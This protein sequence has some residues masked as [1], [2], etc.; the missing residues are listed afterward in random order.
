MTAPS[1]TDDIGICA[2]VAEDWSHAWRSR[3]HVLSRL[4]RYF[5]VVWVDPAPGW[6]SVLKGRSAPERETL[7]QGLI[8][9]KAETWLP[10][11]Q[12]PQWLADLTFDTR[13]RRAR[14]ILMR[15]GCKRIIL[16]LWRPEFARA[17]SSAPFDLTCY[18]I[19]DEYS[20]SST[21]VP[22]APAEIRLVTGVDQVFIHSPGLLERLGGYNPNTD[23][24]PNGVDFAAFA[25][26]VPEPA[27]LASIP[28]PRVGYNG[29]I[30]QHLDWKL[31]RQLAERHPNWSFVFVGPVMH[32]HILPIIEELS[33]RRNVHFLGGKTA[34]ELAQYPQHFDVCVMPYALD[35]YSARFIYPLKLHEYL[36]GGAPVV[37]TRIRSLEPFEH[38]VKLAVSPDEWSDA[39]ASSLDPEV[40]SANQRMAR[41]GVAREHDW[42]VLV[43]KIANTLSYRLNSRSQTAHGRHLEAS[44]NT[45]AVFGE[46]TS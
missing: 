12:R 11:F 25:S 42:N 33:Q 40:N 15:R 34:R 4:S 41:Q 16:Y 7:P 45:R 3:H 24:V 17:V 31:V 22:V 30:K 9:Y 14:S 1:Y 8:R 36:A 44:P 6:R 19:A 26:P 35:D 13:V 18:H 29:W 5:P 46:R 37:G 38:V 20:F 28:R 43:A 27:D 21:E 32:S 2:M 23:F 39:I 10:R